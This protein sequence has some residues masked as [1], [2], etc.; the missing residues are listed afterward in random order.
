MTT[1]LDL[2]EN[3]HPE[4]PE[5][6]DAA[7]AAEIDSVEDVAPTDASHD[8]DSDESI[9][10]SVEST[11]DVDESADD[12]AEDS[13]DESDD[14]DDSD[15]TDDP[16][17]GGVRFADLGLA[18]ELQRA[19]DEL[20]YERPS[21]IQA[22]AIPSLIDGRDLI[23]QAATG[24]GKTAAFALPMLQRL[25]QERRGSRGTAP[26]GLVLAPTRELAM[27]VTEAIARYGKGLRAGCWPS[28]AALPSARSSVRSSVASTSS[29]PPRAARST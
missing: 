14:S 29:S 23:G 9:G 5:F 27:Q 22:E 7:L 4:T 17:E 3:D 11:G 2:P 8:S 25:A 15:D 16:D 12:S 26:L 19:L 24:T 20:G 13:N 21:P 6:D 10:D 1:L 28:T 18:P